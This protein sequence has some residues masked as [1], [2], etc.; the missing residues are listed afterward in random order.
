M[1][2]FFFEHLSFSNLYTILLDFKETGKHNKG[3]RIP[4]N[5]YIIPFGKNTSINGLMDGDKKYL[6]VWDANSV[7]GVQFPTSAR[8]HDIDLGQLYHSLR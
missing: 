1:G 6:S 3:T 4:N 2:N 7:A 5:I 8:S